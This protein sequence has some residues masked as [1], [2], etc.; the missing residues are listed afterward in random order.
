MVIGFQFLAHSRAALVLVG[1]NRSPSVLWNN[2]LVQ[3]MVIFFTF[4]CMSRYIH[5]IGYSFATLFIGLP[6]PCSCRCWL[7]HQGALSKRF[8]FE[9]KHIPLDMGTHFIKSG[10]PVC[11][12]F[13]FRAV[14]SSETSTLRRFTQFM[15]FMQTAQFMQFVR[16]HGR[17]VLSGPP[18]LIWSLY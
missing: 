10:L 8:A 12:V 13:P 7:L 17:P 5:H 11:P 4:G 15:Q 14:Y 16:E 2:F 1:Y 9:R 6:L 3:S 18:G